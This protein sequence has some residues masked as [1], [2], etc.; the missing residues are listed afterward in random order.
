MGRGHHVSSR[1]LDSL[2]LFVPQT[3][4]PS[5][6][7]RFGPGVRASATLGRPRVAN[8]PT[9]L[10][11]SRHL[12]SDPA[13]VRLF[14]RCSLFPLPALC[15]TRRRIFAAG[16]CFI[17]SRVKRYPR[18]H[19]RNSFHDVRGN[20]V[21]VDRR[22]SRESDGNLPSAFHSKQGD[23]AS[24]IAVLFR[25]ISGCRP[26]R[27]WSKGHSGER[28]LLP[29]FSHAQVSAGPCNNKE[30]PPPRCDRARTPTTARFMGTFSGPTAVS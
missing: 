27:Q 22:S 16:L 25:P 29:F 7:P 1:L 6:R 3:T 12:C 19:Q 17:D 14:P 30:A 10:S 23:I 18:S 28:M 13:G 20:Q 2:R 4:V 21:H 11:A 26:R 9:C 8:R 5:L 24:G 15:R